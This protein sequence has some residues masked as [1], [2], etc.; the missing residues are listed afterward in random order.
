MHYQKSER[1]LLNF[2]FYETACNENKV[3]IVILKKIII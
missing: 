2:E 3:I 1:L